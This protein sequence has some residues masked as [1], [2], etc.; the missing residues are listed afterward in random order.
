[1]PVYEYECTDHGVF[2]ALTPLARYAEPAPCPECDLASVRVISTPHLASMAR[3]SY[4][5]AERNERS[6]HEPRM[7]KKDRS[8]HDHKHGVNEKT[9]DPA[10][11]PALRAS[12]G[13]RP[14]ALEHG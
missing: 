7:V 1:M 6:R 11:R 9:R 14:W 4:V 13:S 10:G 3:A 12:H 2:E 5:A 8:G